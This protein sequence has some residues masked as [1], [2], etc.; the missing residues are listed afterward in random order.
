MSQPV[1]MRSA[2]TS[3][4]PT[5]AERPR[6]WYRK[7]LAAALWFA[8][9][10]WFLI[11]VG[12]LIII[13]SQVQVPAA[14]QSIKSE[15]ISYL[16]VAIIFLI[17]GLTLPTKI[18]IA[19]ASRIWLHLF[20][21]SFCFLLDSA[22]VFAVVSIIGTNHHFMDGGL[23]VGLI[24][25]GCIPTT[26][27]SNVVMTRAAHGNDAITVV[28]STLGNVLA[29]FLTPLLIKMYL[30]CDAW[31]THAV[32]PSAS[33]LSDLYRRVFK[34]LGLSMLVPLFVGQLVQNA[35]PAPVKKIMT[36]YKVSK[37][38]SFCLL[39]IIW[40]TYDKGFET[41]T[42]TSV[43]GSNMILVVF[44]S[45]GFYLLWLAL[46]VVLSRLLR[47]SKRD[48][49]AVA[50]CAPAKTP[51]MGV[52]LANAMF[53]H[54]DGVT[55]SKL[56]IPL[57]IFQGLQIAGGSIMTIPFRRW[58]RDEEEQAKLQ[59]AADRTSETTGND[60]DAPV[61]DIEKRGETLSDAKQ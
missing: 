56:Q 11:M 10:Q 48:T 27:S 60:Q 16:C 14:H 54:L 28:E 52:P 17:T 53:A 44:V 15:V 5:I 46:S 23:M 32:P 42:F 37:L 34:Q 61:G 7:L 49:I 45:V 57:V 36:G 43:P 38:S 50:Y 29:P 19:S 59:A 8:M 18:L 3:A 33:D 13:A 4:T 22:S 12:I 25:M 21:Q 31:W 41:G 55:A 2:T 35:F 30:A 6:P 51:A 26:I 20:V 39:V 24:F 40:S 58:V 47:F 9:D 1:Q